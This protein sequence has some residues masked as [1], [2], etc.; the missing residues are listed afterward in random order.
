MV[1][2]PDIK[3]WRPQVDGIAEVL[4]ARITEHVYPMHTHDSWTLLIVDDG[5][6][7]YDLDRHEYGALEQ[8][9][10]L[11]PPH[12]PHNGC[13]VKPTGFRKRVIYLD[14]SQLGDHLIGL[15]VG[16]PACDDPV[17]RE[18][19]HQLHNALT[20]PGDELEADSR[21]AFVAERLRA[22]LERRCEPKEPAADPGLAHRLRE[23]LDECF[24]E[25]VTLREASEQLHAH[26]AHL[27]RV[28]SQEFGMGPHQYLTGRR[29]DLARGLLLAGMAPRAVAASAGFYDQS[30]FTRHFKR[31]LGISPGQ[32][33][34]TGP[35]TGL[36]RVTV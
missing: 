24:V 1:A 22:H 16:N 23:L 4:H 17:L 3:A 10:T 21:L 7:R 26:P 25:G 20:H 34:R 15:A 35:P 5:V 2:R 14:S 32:Y 6:V 29:V 13:S 30:H 33:A 28:F 27:V 8:L 12:V 9:V 36:R 11:L 31:I 18:R 19:I